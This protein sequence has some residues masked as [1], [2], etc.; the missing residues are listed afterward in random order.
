MRIVPILLLLALSGQALAEACVI[1]SQAERLDV[2]LCQQNRNIPQNLF[3]SG[4]CQPQLRGQKVTVEYAEICPQG[5]FG[6]C[7]DA[8]IA[9]TLYKQD[10]HY[11]GVASDSAY[12]KPACEKQS[13]GVWMGQ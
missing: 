2:K 4:F 3:R 8:K 7:R 5:A 12:L 1:H 11:Y 9:G 10:I 13:K 6:V